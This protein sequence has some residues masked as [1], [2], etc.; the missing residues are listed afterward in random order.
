MAVIRRKP[1]MESTVAFDDVEALYLPRAVD[2]TMYQ[3][4]RWP[5]WSPRAPPSGPREE[6]I[7]R[8][9]VC[10][11]AVVDVGGGVQATPR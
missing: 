11:A 5:E 3:D 10:G 2:M 1:R 7:R 4:P 9:D 6:S 8:V